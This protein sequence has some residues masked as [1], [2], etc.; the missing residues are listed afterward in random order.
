ML[1]V[2]EVARINVNNALKAGNIERATILIDRLFAEQ[3]QQYLERDL[4][5]ELISIPE[6]QERLQNIQ[7]A[8]GTQ[9]TIIY[10]LAREERLDL[11]MIPPDGELIYRSVPDA[12]R[13]AL[14]TVVRDL[15][16]EITNPMKRSVKN[17]LLPAQQLYQWMIAP[18]A[19][20]L[21]RL[22]IDTLVFSLDGG[23]RSLPVAALH[24]GQQFLVE[25][26]SMSLIPSVNLVDTTYQSLKDARI[27]AMGA[28]EF[29]ELPPLPAVPVEVATITSQWEGAAFLNKALPWI[30]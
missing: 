22:E 10:A 18:L 25:N 28:S 6:L 8:T 11:I 9:P 20:D 30:I 1:S 15:R 24:D 16:N 3:F 17:Y 12:H 7:K 27:L 5:R 13:E 23:L 29:E 4:S 26:Y 21:E 2:T 19:A 14:L